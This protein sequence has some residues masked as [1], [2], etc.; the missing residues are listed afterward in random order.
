MRL[1][2]TLTCSDDGWTLTETG[3]DADRALALGSNFM[4]GNGYLGYRAT[5]AEARAG[6]YVALVV[7]DTSGAYLDELPNEVTG[8]TSA[9]FETLYRTGV[10]PK[11]QR[12][13]WWLV[14]PRR[15]RASTP[16]SACT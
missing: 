11:V 3:W 7:S 14:K 5:P 6:D 10:S 16:A 2:E 13:I 4:A 1:S 12:S 8:T 9:C 15:W